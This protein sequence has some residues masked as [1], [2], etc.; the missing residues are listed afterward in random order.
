MDGGASGIRRAVCG[1]VMFDT[2]FVRDE[3]IDPRMWKAM[4]KLKHLKD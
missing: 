2:R 4:S 1:I 3:R